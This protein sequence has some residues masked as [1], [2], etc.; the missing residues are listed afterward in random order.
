[1]I[2]LGF[3]N[4][5]TKSD[6]ILMDKLQSNNGLFLMWKL[7]SKTKEMMSSLQLRRISGCLLQSKSKTNNI[8]IAYNCNCNKFV[9]LEMWVMHLVYHPRSEK[10]WTAC[11]VHTP[12]GLLWW[13]IYKSKPSVITQQR[14]A[15]ESQLENP[16]KHL[17][18]PYRG[19]QPSSL[20]HGQESVTVNSFDTNDPLGNGKE[21]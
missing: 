17:L 8:D 6:H 20:I 21:L 7:N 9:L 13:F 14:P 2:S 18:E 16:S 5:T 3:Q 1:M 10:R 4:K 12:R 11:G 19:V 15:E